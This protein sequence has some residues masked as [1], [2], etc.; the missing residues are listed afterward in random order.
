MQGWVKGKDYPEFMTEEALITL[1]AGY[2]HNGE[3][4]VEMYRRVAKAAAYRLKKP[5]LEEK[6]FDYIYKNWLCLA[7]PVASNLGTERGL[8]ISCYGSH[9]PDSI[10]GIMDSMKEGAAMSKNGGGVGMYW[11]GV[12]GRGEPITGNGV[13]SGIVPWLK[14]QDSL[15]AGVNQ[16]TV[17]KGASVAYLP[18]D[19]KDVKEFLRIRRPQGDVNRQCMNIHHAVCITDEFMRKV[20][21]GDGQTR[22]LWKEILKTRLETGEPYLM[23]SDNVNNN[24]PEAYVKNN[25]KVET[26]QLCSEIF[27]Y[28]DEF[29]SFV[30]CLSS[31]NLARYNE[32]KDTD[33]PETA[34]WF[35][36]AVM[37]EFIEKAEQIPSLERAVR[38]AKKSRALGLGVLGWH[39]LLQ[40]EGTPFNS[41]RAYLLNRSIFEQIRKGV[42]KASKDLAAEYGEVEWTRG[43]GERNTHKLAVAP[44][45]SNSL[46]SGDGN[47]GGVSPSVECWA[48]NIFVQK[49]AKGNFIRKNPALK[50]KLEESGK[51][52]PEVW[53]QIN[54]QGG[55]VQGL[56]FLSEEDKEVFL[57][58]REVSQLAVVKQAA[59]RQK[60]LDQGQSLN[61]YFPA[62]VDLRYFNKVHLEAWNRGLFSLYYVR[63]GS[64][65]KG[66]VATRSNHKMVEEE[67]PACKACEG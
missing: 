2:L 65:L 48:S 41:L 54:A 20:E 50:A 32:W 45:V 19:H 22:E 12:R 51:N 21:N 49:T 46:L 38:F 31:L 17:R 14:I 33:L 52:T 37:E 67:E 66:D 62:D 63:S 5:N 42:D 58:A 30:C 44:T 59:E 15:T 55:S 13:S 4:P 40:A 16:G 34:I 47:G 35:L 11:G 7:S 9:V 26:S 64:V 36:D 61:L 57:T 18:V 53:N 6:F 39:S 1:N 60:F 29:H 3:T 8:P 43:T 24:R 28:T 27:L 25:L 56:D 10:E 23:F